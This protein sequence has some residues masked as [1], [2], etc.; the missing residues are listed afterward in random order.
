[1]AIVRNKEHR[2]FAFR[3]FAHLQLTLYLQTF[4]DTRQDTTVLPQTNK[5]FV[6]PKN[7][8]FL[9]SNACPL[10]LQDVS[11][12]RTVVLVNGVTV[13]IV[14]AN[15]QQTADFKL[16]LSTTQLLSMDHVLLQLLPVSAYLA[17]VTL[18]VVLLFVVTTTITLA[19]YPSPKIVLREFVTPLIPFVEFPSSVLDAQHL[20]KPNSVV[21]V[22]VTVILA[23]PVLLAT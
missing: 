18:L 6:Y 3:K 14:P 21:V 10:V 4:V 2:L 9:L 11:L 20:R 7:A 16:I 12:M 23:Q 8:V 1:M 5:L 13:K 22:I 17:F 19:T 15:M